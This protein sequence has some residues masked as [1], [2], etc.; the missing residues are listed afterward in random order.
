MSFFT[1]KII[2]YCL[3]VSICFNLLSLAYIGRRAYYTYIEVSKEV[4]RKNDSP[5]RESLEAYF[6]ERNE[7]YSKFPIQSDDIVFIGNSLTEMFNVTEL[8][9]NVKNRGIGGDKSRG[10]LF[11]LA[12]IVEGKPKKIFGSSVP[13]AQKKI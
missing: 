10:L 2:K 3:I 1:P 13:L 5:T 6:K 8:F 4:S 7:Y 9:G 11:R 12:S